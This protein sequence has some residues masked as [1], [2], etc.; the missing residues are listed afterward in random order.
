VPATEGGSCRGRNGGK[1]AGVRRAALATAALMLACNQVNL[2]GWHVE[3]VSGDGG[4]AVRCLAPEDCPR[5]GGAVVCD[6]TVEPDRT[7]V[8][9]AQGACERVVAERCP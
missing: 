7:C 9:C 1:T 5:T 2:C 6:T 8:R 4:V 3:T